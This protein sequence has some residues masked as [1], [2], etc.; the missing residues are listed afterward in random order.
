MCHIVLRFYGDLSLLGDETC[1][2]FVVD[3]SAVKR[4]LLTHGLH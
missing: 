1:D 4:Y 3:I 2:V